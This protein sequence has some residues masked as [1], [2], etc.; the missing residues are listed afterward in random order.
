[1]ALGLLL[2]ACGGTSNGGQADAG[3]DVTPHTARGKFCNGVS[4]PDGSAYTMTLKIGGR[5]LTT[6]TGSCTACQSLPAGNAGFQVEVQGIGV[7]TSGTVTIVGGEE[8]LYWTDLDS[9]SR[10]V[11]RGGKIELPNNC[12]SAKP[13]FE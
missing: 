7:G 5:S 13:K 3:G 4:R 10:L 8:Y 9:S 12:A 2:A 1:V 6:V 11:L